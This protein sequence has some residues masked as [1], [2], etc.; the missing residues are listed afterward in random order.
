MGCCANCC[1]S[2][3][4]T[5]MSLITLGVTA[6]V[7]IILTILISEQKIKEVSNTIYILFI[8]ATVIVCLV[9]VFAIYASC[10]GGKVSKTI[11]GIIFIVLG[12]ILLVFGIVVLA[13]KEDISDFI[14]KMFIPGT[15]E[16][17]DN[18]NARD[19]LARFFKCWYLGQGPVD[20]ER[21]DACTTVVGDKFEQ[22]DLACGILLIIFAVLMAISAIVC[23]VYVCK[24]GKV[25]N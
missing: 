5:L 8:V 6:V 2:L 14:T 12:V 24:N 9:L 15:E 19:V 21:T 1:R 18:P 22:Y 3:W 16:Y 23:F 20:F 13:F 10:C 7:L 11:L 4:L 25:S 17:R